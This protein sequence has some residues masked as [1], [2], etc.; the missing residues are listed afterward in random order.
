MISLEKMVGKF[1]ETLLKTESHDFFMR[2]LTNE[3]IS[4]EQH[5]Q[6]LKNS[7]IVG[8]MFWMK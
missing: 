6:S 5:K 2:T 4:V 8:I 7:M 1:P 3:E